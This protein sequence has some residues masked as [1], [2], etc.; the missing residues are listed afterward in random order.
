M[1]IAISIVLGHSVQKQPYEVSPAA[2]THP[3]EIRSH[4]ALP[5]VFQELATSRAAK[6]TFSRHHV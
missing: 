5:F 2:T 4:D 6:T 1:P 3:A